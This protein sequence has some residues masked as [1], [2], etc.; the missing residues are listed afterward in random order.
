SRR[1]MRGKDW[2]VYRVKASLKMPNTVP[3]LF[4]NPKL[5][6]GDGPAGRDDVAALMEGLK[7][8]EARVRLEAAEDLGLMGPAAKDAVPALIKL[9]ENDGDR[10]IRLE[11]AKALAYIDPKNE[12]AIPLLIE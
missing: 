11:A 10:L 5:L 8:D 9:S 1:L 7:H 3:E 6:V 12:T 2:P 4:Y